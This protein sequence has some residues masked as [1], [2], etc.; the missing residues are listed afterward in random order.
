VNE[1][2]PAFGSATYSSTLAE[3]EAVSTAVLTVAATDADDGNDGAI[4][5]SMP[6]DTHFMININTGVIYLKAALDYETATSHTFK[7]TAS[8]AG[9][10]VKTATSDITI[11]V[12]DVNDNTPSC[13]PLTYVVTKREDVGA[14][15]SIATLSCSDADGTSTHNTQSYTITTVNGVSGAGVFAIDSAGAV[16]TTGLDYETAAS[17]DIVITVSDGSLTDT[18][19]IAVEV[20]D[21]NEAAP[22]F[23]AQPTTANVAESTAVGTSIV[24]IVATD[25]DSANT[26]TYEF[27]PTSTKFTIDASTGEIYLMD[28]VDKETTASYSL[29]IKVGLGIIICN[30][31][32]GFVFV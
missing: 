1:F 20:T 8:D 26:L 25:A 21:V 18:V 2:D 30:F 5:Y 22:T 11:T 16:T 29:T 6:S 27:N 12:T 24:T 13:S 7:V 31:Y 19:Y 15:T 28:V 10:P 17:H 23:S 3:T 32:L 9:S 4:S 14:G